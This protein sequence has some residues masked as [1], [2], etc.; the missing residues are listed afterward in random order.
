MSVTNGITASGALYLTTH[1]NLVSIS[2]AV[3][4]ASGLRVGMASED[5]QK[6]MQHHA[7]IQTNV[8]AISLDR[9]KTMACPYPLP[10][11]TTLMLDMHGTKAPTGGLF[12][13]SNPVF[14]RAYIQSQGAEIIS[15]TPSNGPQQNAPAN[16][17][18]PFAPDTNRTSRGAGSDG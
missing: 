1:S 10:G 18:Q 9:G 7:M 5:V 4:I 2:N 3:K 14:D 8:Y 15:I 11:G 16:R 17:S 13:W 6:Y 12:G